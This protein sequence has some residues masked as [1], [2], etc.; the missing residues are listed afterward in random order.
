[1][2]TVDSRQRMAMQGRTPLTLSGSPR[3][4]V[5]ASP[6]GPSPPCD[7]TRRDRGL[8]RRIPARAADR[9]QQRGHDF[10]PQP[11]AA[12]LL[13]ILETYNPGIR[14]VLAHTAEVLAGDHAVLSRAVEVAWTSLMPVEVPEEVRFSLPVW[15]GLPLGLSAPPS[16]RRSI[17][18][19]AA[20]ATSTGS[21]SSGRYGWRVRAH[22]AG[23]DP[24]RGA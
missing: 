13:P 2:T 7:P 8:L 12:E 17:G 22:R 15:R 20:C 4:R 18:C 21:T 10:L 11:A 5:A 6:P 23:G 16:V 3:L 24:R 19:G 9:P 14:D 1:M